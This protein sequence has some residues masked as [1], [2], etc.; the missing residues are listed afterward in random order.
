MVTILAAGIGTTID[1][2]KN[3]SFYKKIEMI[4]LTKQR[5]EHHIKKQMRMKWIGN[6]TGFLHE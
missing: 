1:I 4:H 6:S 3:I 2:S 5:I